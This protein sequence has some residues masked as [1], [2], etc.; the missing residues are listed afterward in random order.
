MIGL[1]TYNH[2]ISTYNKI[3]IIWSLSI[4]NIRNG[5]IGCMGLK[6]NPIVE[7]IPYEDKTDSKTL[8]NP[9]EPKVV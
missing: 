8:I 3:K 6:T 7:Q 5:I 2:I 1:D 4:P 9:I